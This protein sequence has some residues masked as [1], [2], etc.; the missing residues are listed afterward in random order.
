[1]LFTPLKNRVSMQ[2]THFTHKQNTQLFACI[3][4][5]VKPLT[6]RPINSEIDVTAIKVAGSAPTSKDRTKLGMKNS[7]WGT[8]RDIHITDSVML[9]NVGLQHSVKSKYFFIV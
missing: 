5:N 2:H 9:I 7:T 1:M 3:I 4:D 8:P 6:I